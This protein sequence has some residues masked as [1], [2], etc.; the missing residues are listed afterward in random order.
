MI[1]SFINIPQ[2]QIILFKEYTAIIVI[3]IKKY[4]EYLIISIFP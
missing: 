1:L 4:Y 2:T 3:T